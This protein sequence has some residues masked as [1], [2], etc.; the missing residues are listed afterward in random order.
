MNGAFFVLHKKTPGE[1]GWPRLT[2]EEGDDSYI[3]FDDEK[4]SLW[5]AG[6]VVQFLSM[7]AN[8]FFSQGF[9]GDKKD[10]GAGGLDDQFQNGMSWDINYEIG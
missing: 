9:D 8:F 2:K 1:A 5:V 3:L 4:V 6:R 7:S 10:Q